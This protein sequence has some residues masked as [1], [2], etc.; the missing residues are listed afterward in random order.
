MSVSSKVSLSLKDGKQC[1]EIWK[2]TGASKCNI[3]PNSFEI[4]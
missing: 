4:L 3:F 1:K 2:D